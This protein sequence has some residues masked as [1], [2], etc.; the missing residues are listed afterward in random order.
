LYTKPEA[1]WIAAM[2]KLIIVLVAASFG[3][4]SC[5]KEAKL[6]NRLDGKWTLD[7]YTYVE[8]KDIKF[9]S[10]DTAY[11]DSSRK[12]SSVDPLISEV[13]VGDVD[14][15]SET[16][17]VMHQ[18]ITETETEVLDNG[19]KT[20]TT[21][22]DENESTHEYFISD[23]DEITLITKD[24]NG[25][26]YKVFEVTTNEKDAQVWEYTKVSNS[27]SPSEVYDIELM[28]DIT[29]G[30]EETVTRTNIVISLSLVK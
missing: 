5:N 26:D 20:F 21:T 25:E 17:F 11:I 19:S 27:T 13:V 14:F 2:K 15:V 30:Y 28:D 18:S 7:S 24:K 4:T 12:E 3:L 16:K 23:E 9:I 29:I 8:T 10:T 22:Q 1:I 6:G